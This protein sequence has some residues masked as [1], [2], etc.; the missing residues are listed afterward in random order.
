M[1]IFP[2]RRKYLSF[3]WTFSS[4]CTRYFEFSVL[5]FGL[6]SAPYLFTKLL[7]P[8]VKKKKKKKKK[9]I[10]IRGESDRCVLG[11]WPRSRCR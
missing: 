7:R 6:S 8:L 4:G 9:K 3:A 10:G 11:R 2:E 5:P 1:E